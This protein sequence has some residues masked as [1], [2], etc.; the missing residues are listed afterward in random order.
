MSGI[1]EGLN[2]GYAELYPVPSLTL[3]PTIML[4]VLIPVITVEPI[5]IVPVTLIESNLIVAIP[6]AVN[7]VVTPAGASIVTVGVD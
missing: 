7:C 5:P 1:W 2:L 3:S 4:V 6:V